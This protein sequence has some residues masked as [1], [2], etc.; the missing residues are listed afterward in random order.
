MKIIKKSAI[1]TGAFS[2]KLMQVLLTFILVDF[3]WIFFRA[4]SLTSAKTLI[5][6]L[7]CFNPGIFTERTIF[8]LGLDSKDFMLA[9][10]GIGVIL[11][12][13]ILQRK[14]NLRVQLSKQNIVLRWIIYITSVIAILIFGI[15]GPGFSAQQFI[16]FQF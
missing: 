12:I 8:S 13:N 4:N 6:N 10:L 3:A 15:Y 1:R 11:F 16:Y 9:L 5:L 2:Y 14:N 7:N